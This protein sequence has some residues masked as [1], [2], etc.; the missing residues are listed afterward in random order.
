MIR[1]SIKHCSVHTTRITS[2]L[3]EAPVTLVLVILL[4]FFSWAGLASA[5]E[6][7]P[8]LEEMWKII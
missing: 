1:P 8:S 3:I 6:A 2:L 4:S 5:D 7:T